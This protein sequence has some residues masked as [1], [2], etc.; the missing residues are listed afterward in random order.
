M[1][2][3]KSLP[4]PFFQLRLPTI[5]VAVA[6]SVTYLIWGSTYLGAAIVLESYGPFTLTA[7]R[8]AVSVVILFAVLKARKSRFPSAR[9]MLA[10]A[11]TGAL[12]FSGAG[13]VALGQDVGV[14]SGLTSL[15]VG[16]VPIWATLIAFF[17][18][19]RPGHVEVLG[20]A[21]GISGVAILNMES[22]MQALPLGALILLVGPMLWAFGTVLS[23]RLS[24]PSG[25]MAVFCQMI[26]GLAAL[27]LI[28]FLR[29]ERFP[30]APSALSTLTLIYLAVIGTLVGFC[31][32]MYLVRAVRP[33]LA[34]SYA[35]VNPFIAV[36]LGAWLLAEPVS[37]TGILAMLVIITG[38]VLVMIG[39]RR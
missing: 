17:F 4:K 33:A 19:H 10:A 25:F 28:S 21:I 5:R 6:L 29:G 9:R 31:A 8:L 1:T 26:G 30:A 11:L 38:V 18:G 3:I 27:I 20:L 22:G 24:L 37:G 36:I 15:A 13:M 16:A 32:Y 2:A 23:S 35:Y 12:M 34:T 39:K 7:I 14:G